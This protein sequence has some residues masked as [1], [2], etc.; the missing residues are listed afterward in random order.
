MASSA[1]PWRPILVYAPRG[2]RRTT[3][4]VSGLVVLA[5]LIAG[6]IMART[7]ALA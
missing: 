4:Q 2:P 7:A 3:V 6:A 5:A 1:G